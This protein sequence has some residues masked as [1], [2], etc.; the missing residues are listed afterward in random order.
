MAR[1][2]ILE[3]LIKKIPHEEVD[4]M[5]L[6]KLTEGFSGAEIF[7]L[8]R[9]ASIKQ[10]EE[11][12]NAKLVKKEHFIEAIKGIKPSITIDTIQFYEKFKK[13]CGIQSI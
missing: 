9:E 2:E 8:G 7:S 12:S 6:A 13:S 3:N 10:L 11:D 4:I 5:E 1:K